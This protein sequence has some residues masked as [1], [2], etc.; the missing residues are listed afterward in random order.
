VVRERVRERD[1]QHTFRWG[2]FFR[3][4]L[5]NHVSAVWTRLLFACLKPDDT[6]TY[7]HIFEV[8]IARRFVVMNR[9]GSVGGTG[10][11]VLDDTRP[12]PLQ[13]TS[14]DAFSLPLRLTLASFS[15]LW[16]CPS[17]TIDHCVPPLRDAKAGDEEDTQ[18]YILSQLTF[19][20]PSIILVCD[21]EKETSISLP[22]FR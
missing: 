15:A 18:T 22:C 2:C 20:S 17:H 3:F 7:F 10:T 12:A 16:V 14:I 1:L 4:Q 21:G 9:V 5:W 11:A 6:A 13:T 19:I 8:E